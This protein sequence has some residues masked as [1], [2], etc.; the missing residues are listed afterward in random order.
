MQGPDDYSEDSC[1]PDGTGT[2]EGEDT[3]VWYDTDG[4]QHCEVN[5]DAS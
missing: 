1:E 2:Y 4:D 3:S 5:E